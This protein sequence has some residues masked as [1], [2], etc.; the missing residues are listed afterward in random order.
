MAKRLAVR[1]GLVILTLS[2]LCGCQEVARDMLRAVSPE[3]K[4]KDLKPPTEQEAN[5][6]AATMQQ[7]IDAGD[8]AA[9]E[10]L[11]DFP[12]IVD[13]ALAGAQLPKASVAAT[14]QGVA[15]GARQTGLIAQLAG[16]H[17]ANVDW[18][19]LSTR[20]DASG[21]WV[22]FR[23][24]PPD[25]GFE[26][27]DFLLTQR[28]DG[29]V[30][31]ADV[32]LLS[33][34]ELISASMRRLLIGAFATD[35]NFLER[36]SAR[37]NLFVKHLD[38]LNAVLQAQARGASDEALGLLDRLPQALQDEKFALLMRLQMTAG[39]P[40]DPRYAACVAR[41]IEK[42][43]ADQAAMIASI[44]HYFLKKEYG[45]ALAAIEAVEK[46]SVPDAY[47]G[48]LRVNA[49]V[50]MNELDRAK[51]MALQTIAREPSLLPAH[52]ALTNVLLVQRAHGETAEQLLKMR[53]QFE[54]AY[55]LERVP[56]YAAFVASAEYPAFK[57]RLDGAQ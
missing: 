44:D 45:K 17:A 2:S 7:A 3:V 10:R 56:E 25:G 36:L 22:S 23:S 12:L 8:A 24:L 55:E 9:L 39:K 54:L 34:S 35:K 28:E 50:A 26:H 49:L 19:L 18:T 53:D 46:R 30:V 43:P 32:F 40:D 5:A 41:L 52:F 47:F 42:Y 51:A 6:Y 21:R 14:A 11:I 15:T 16:L 29:S 20:V 33:S 57:R 31:A 37:E 1:I 27:Y 38:D 48:V 13:R 4:P